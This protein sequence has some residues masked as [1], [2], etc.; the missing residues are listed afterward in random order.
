MV[1][2]PS[3]FPLFEGEPVS[4]PGSPCYKESHG[5]EATQDDTIDTFGGVMTS[6]HGD[7]GRPQ[8]TIDQIISCMRLIIVYTVTMGTQMDANCVGLNL[9]TKLHSMMLSDTTTLELPYSG[10]LSREKT[11][12]NW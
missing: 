1:S 7:Q 6:Y 11:F 10:K 3:S 2:H 5:Y 4:F 8:H 12:A 9:K